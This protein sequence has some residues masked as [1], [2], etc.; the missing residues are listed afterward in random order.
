MNTTTSKPAS[1][2]TLKFLHDLI[3]GKDEVKLSEMVKT[4]PT[5]WRSLWN[6]VVTGFVNCDHEG[7][8]PEA[9]NLWFAMEEWPMLEQNDASK[10]IEQLKQLPWASK[11]AQ[12]TASEPVTEPGMYFANGGDTIYK[13]QKAVHG[14]GNLYA[15]ELVVEEPDCGGC[16]NGE[17]CGAG[18]KWT[19]KFVYA[20][21]AI[22]R[23]KASDKMTYEQARE[24]GAVYGT[25]VNCGRTLTNELSIAL[26]I[27]PVCGRRQFGGDFEFL[28]DKAKAGLK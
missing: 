13:V 12:E 17:P 11:K 4:M 3:V 8:G 27:G 18:C 14:S 9:L 24:F 15:K 26:G 7:Y 25:C 23:L 20:P 10:F 1:E 6:R 21:G 5:D 28:I 22:K 2:R 19:V 16:A